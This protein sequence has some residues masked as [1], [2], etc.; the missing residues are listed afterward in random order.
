MVKKYFRDSLETLG[1]FQMP[2]YKYRR[3][4]GS[5]SIQRGVQSAGTFRKYKAKS[6]IT[7]GK[8]KSSPI[9]NA[10]QTSPNK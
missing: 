6:H 9:I 4:K 5:I 10:K 7:T 2:L 3:Q 8:R 1:N